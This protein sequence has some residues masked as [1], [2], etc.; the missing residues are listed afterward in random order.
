MGV[1]RDD[2]IVT[3]DPVFTLNSI[4]AAD[5]EEMLQANGIPMD[6]PFVGVSIR[7]WTG[8]ESFCGKTAVLCDE[9]HKK[10]RLQYRIHRHADAL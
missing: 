8:M 1:V 9:I 3:A 7:Y 10:I 6:K 2:L 4:P 5:A